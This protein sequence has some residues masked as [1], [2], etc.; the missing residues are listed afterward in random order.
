MQKITSFRDVIDLF[1]SRVG[2]GQALGW[3]GATVR[4]W[5]VRNSIP[6]PVWQSLVAVCREA[7]H[8]HVTPDLLTRLAAGGGHLSEG[9][10][11]SDLDSA[12]L[13][14]QE[15]EGVGLVRVGQHERVQGLDD[16]AET[17]A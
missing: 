7:G 11:E 16:A 5:R 15:C 17:G 9:G 3:D 14:D 1:P 12:C 8:S 4:A 10:V 13:A 2:L 6:S